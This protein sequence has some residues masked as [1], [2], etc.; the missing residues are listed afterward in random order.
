MTQM[1]RNAL[2]TP[3]GTI[4][5]SYNRHDYK[6]Y[7]DANGKEYMIDGGLDYIRSSANGDEQYLTVTTDDP[8]ETIR[9][10]LKWGTRGPDG[11]QPLEYR[12]LAK[13]DT[14]HVHAILETQT[15]I[16]PWLTKVFETE[17]EFR[18]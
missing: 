13:L 15:H 6:T 17:L 3:D 2:R 5:E 18:A 10:S 4:I 9:E 11:K 8:F 7:T 16:A 1:V 14:E 12:V